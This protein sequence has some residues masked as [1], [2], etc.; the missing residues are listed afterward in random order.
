VCLLP[1]PR[2]Q[3]TLQRGETYQPPKTKSRTNA[4]TTRDAK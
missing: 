3:S 4:E 2:D 1:L